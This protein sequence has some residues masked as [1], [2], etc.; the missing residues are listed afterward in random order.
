[1]IH[2]GLGCSVKSRPD[3]SGTVILTRCWYGARGAGA[4]GTAAQS[5]LRQAQLAQM[6]LTNLYVGIA[7]GAVERF[8]LHLS[9]SRPFPA[10]GVSQA[11]DDPLHPA[12]VWRTVKVAAVQA[13]AELAAQQ[14]TAPSRPVTARHDRISVAAWLLR[15]RKPRVLAHQA[16]LDVSTGVRVDQIVPP[17]CRW[18]GPLWRNARVHTLH[19]PVDY[20][21]RGMGRH[22]AVELFR[23]RTLKTYQYAIN[24]GYPAMIAWATGK[25][26]S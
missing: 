18:A 14:L 13:L 22:C 20:K 1:M 8:G 16:A 19:D 10:A 15:W 2:G 11:V 12:P 9:S 17:K 7:Q 5:A 23:R 4:T 26:A 24:S 6:I 25:F 21:L 3:N